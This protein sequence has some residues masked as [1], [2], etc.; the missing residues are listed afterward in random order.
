MDQVRS[1]DSGPKVLVRRRLLAAG[2][3]FRLHR[4]DLPGC[5]AVVLPRHRVAVFVHGRFWHGQGCQAARS[6]ATNQAFWDA[7]IDGD[8]EHD[9]RW[10]AELEVLSWRVVVPSTCESE[11]GFEDLIVTLGAPDPTL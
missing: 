7:N 5:P 8:M 2:N 10:I 6:P 11:T 3:R 1:K 9:L 4:G